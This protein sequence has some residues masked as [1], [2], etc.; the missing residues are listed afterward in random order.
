M[1]VYK[2][3]RAGEW[4]ELD[5]GG[6]SLGAPA[7]RADGFVH[8][9]TAG[10]LAETLARHFAEETG[11]ILAALDAAAIGGELD[12]EPSRGG[13]LFPHLYRPLRRADILWTRPIAD[14][15]GGPIAPDGLV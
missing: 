6:E 13:L 5:A 7:D 9:S 8:L 4:A 3:L 15:P 11:L 12:W 10:Q 1:L 2:V 14:G